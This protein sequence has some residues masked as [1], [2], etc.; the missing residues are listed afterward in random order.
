MFL[1]CRSRFGG[2][3]HCIAV[4]NT[5]SKVVMRLAPGCGELAVVYMLE[6]PG[7]EYAEVVAGV[8]GVYEAR[9][10]DFDRFL[11]DAEL[12]LRDAHDVVCEE[13]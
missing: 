8:L 11:S 2:M 4:W 1:R 7:E 12:L 6:G 5:G 13:R 10:F 9:D 3:D